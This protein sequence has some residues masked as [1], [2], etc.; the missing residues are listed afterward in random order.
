MGSTSWVWEVML[1][2]VESWVEIPAVIEEPMV[3]F[4]TIIMPVKTMRN[5]RVLDQV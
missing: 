1:K 4:M 3:E 2:E 5:L